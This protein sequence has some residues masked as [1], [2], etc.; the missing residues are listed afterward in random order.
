MSHA[1]ETWGVGLLLFWV[2][3]LLM[4]LSGPVSA[5]GP[6]CVPSRPQTAVISP[7]MACHRARLALAHWRNIKHSLTAAPLLAAAAILRG[8]HL[9]AMLAS[10]LTSHVRKSLQ[11]GM[12]LVY[13]SCSARQRER[14]MFGSRK[15]ETQHNTTVLLIR[16]V[17]DTQNLEVKA[18]S[19]KF[20]RFSMP[21]SIPRQ[22]TGT[23]Q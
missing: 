9:A 18:D 19:M 4:S 3:A 5:A 23:K 11:W 17:R 13:S 10:Y 12:Q 14:D 15:D 1:S 21:N 2:P 6:A 8:I 16:D 22:K 20:P 7:V